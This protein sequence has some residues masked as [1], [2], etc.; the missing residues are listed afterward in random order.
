[1]SFKNSYTNI[2]DKGLGFNCNNFK[3]DNHPEDIESDM[4]A[5]WNETM[6]PYIGYRSHF[7]DDCCAQ[8]VVTREIIRK[9]PLEF[10]KKHYDWLLSTELPSSLSARF[11]EWTWKVIFS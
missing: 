1:M 3:I 4:R 2:N 5:W 8:F 11:Y 6:Q 10:Y 9:H 7:R